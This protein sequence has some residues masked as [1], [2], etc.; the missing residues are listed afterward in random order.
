MRLHSYTV[1]IT[2]LHAG[3]LYPGPFNNYGDTSKPGPWALDWTVDWTMDPDWTTYV[4][5][6]IIVPHDYNSGWGLV[7]ESGS[8]M[9][10]DSL[11]QARYCAVFSELVLSRDYQNS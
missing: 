4:H 11:S 10:C 9:S 8:P 6:G 1:E 5:N 7:C 3:T 2:S